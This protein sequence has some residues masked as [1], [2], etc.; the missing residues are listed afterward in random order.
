MLCTHCTVLRCKPVGAGIATVVHAG[1]TASDLT[2]QSTFEYDLVMLTSQV[3][4]SKAYLAQ[5]ASVQAYFVN[6]I[7]GACHVPVH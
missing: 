1:Q 4:S 5:N 7:A 2:T 3:V 6:D